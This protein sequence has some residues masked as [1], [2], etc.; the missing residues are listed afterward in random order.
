MKEHSFRYKM[1]V[2]RRW[3]AEFVRG[4]PLCVRSFT[5]FREPREPRGVVSVLRHALLPLLDWCGALPYD[6]VAALEVIW[7]SGKNVAFGDMSLIVGKEYYIGL[8]CIKIQV[9]M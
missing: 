2:S 4:S 3:A 1:S 9:R 5:L 8:T 7:Q 6:Y